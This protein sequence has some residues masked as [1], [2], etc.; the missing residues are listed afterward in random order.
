MVIYIPTEQLS[1]SKEGIFSMEL[2]VASTVNN[3][4]IK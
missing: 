1:A 4:E 3:K 2:I